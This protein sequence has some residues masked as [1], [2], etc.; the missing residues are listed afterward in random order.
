MALKDGAAN[1]I[2]RLIGYESGE[3]ALVWQG[4]VAGKHKALAIKT[5]RTPVGDPQVD[6]IQDLWKLTGSKASGA[7]SK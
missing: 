4:R 7:A 1:A 3:L 6:S 2:L 5:N